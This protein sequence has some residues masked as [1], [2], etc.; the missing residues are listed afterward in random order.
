MSDALVRRPPTQ[1]ELLMTSTA[2]PWK[3]RDPKSKSLATQD[4]DSESLG[5]ISNDATM[6]NLVSRIQ[7][8]VV[9]RDMAVQAPKMITVPKGYA[10]TYDT[11]PADHFRDRREVKVHVKRKRN[12][13]MLSKP[14][15]ELESNELYGFRA[16][17]VNSAG[18]VSLPNCQASSLTN[19][20]HPLLGRARFDDTPDVIYDQLAPALRLAS[21]FLTQPV[22]MQ[23]WVTL[24]FAKRKDD[25]EMSLKYGKR[26]QRIDEHIGM[27]SENTASVTKRLEDMGN[28]NLIH[29]A[30]RNKTA[31]PQTDIWGCS[32]PIRDYRGAVGR[33]LTKSLIRLH[34]DYYI[35]AEKLSQLKYPEQSQN[36]RFSFIFAVIILHEL[37]SCPIKH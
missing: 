22:C 36:L 13:L 18:A 6:A 1:T 25:P 4:T 10:V 35:V 24:A 11:K 9:I 15:R 16:H 5:L 32:W 23:F 26:C 8:N 28:A 31:M 30:F 17:E 14:L 3:E 2:I 19:D 27:T 29:F 12:E 7:D 21:M 34:A 33:N 20:I 37:V